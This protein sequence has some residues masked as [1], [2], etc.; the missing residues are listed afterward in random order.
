MFKVWFLISNFTLFKDIM[1]WLNQSHVNHKSHV[2]Q[3]TIIMY[4]TKVLKTLRLFC[5]CYYLKVHNS[6]SNAFV[7]HVFIQQLHFKA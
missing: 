1:F 4:H 2:S 6:H 7:F 3:I 5:A